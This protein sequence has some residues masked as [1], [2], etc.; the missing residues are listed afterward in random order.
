MLV[1]RRVDGLYG[2]AHRA[3]TP[4]AADSPPVRF[5]IARHT[6]NWPCLDRNRRFRT[7]R[8]VFV[9]TPSQQCANHGGTVSAETQ[10]GAGLAPLCIEHCFSTRRPGVDRFHFLSESRLVPV[11]S[12]SRPARS[13]AAP[14]PSPAQSNALLKALPAAEWQRWRQHLEPMDMARDRLMWEPGV[15]IQFVYFPTTAIVSLMYVTRDGASTEFAVVGN[16]G[17]VGISVL[18]GSDSA[19]SRA[20]VQCAGQSYRF[21][22]RLIKEE[23]RNSEAVRGLLLPYMQAVITQIAQAVACNRQH[24]IDQQLCRLLLLHLDR[25]TLREL[26][27]T[28]ESIANRIGVRREGITE[29]ALKLQHAGVIHYGRGRITVVDRPALERRTC[30]CYAVVKLEGERLRR[31]SMH[32]QACAEPNVAPAAS[33]WP[34]VGRS[35]RP[36]AE[37]PASAACSRS[38]PTSV[39]RR[40]S[41]A[42]GT[43][44]C[45]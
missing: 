20:V 3:R 29:A 42:S 45:R 39:S 2:T 37:D 38:I 8:Y 36:Q 25:S 14:P 26:A 9:M 23:F 40:S 4:L 27:L 12:I 19:V 17:L 15:P 43:A 13:L 5:E 30:E 28:Q 7:I 1:C 16:E 33:T 31:Q 41:R 21:P 18:L 10:Y 44:A 11:H 6:R 32:S 34:P 22:A 24:S 35:S